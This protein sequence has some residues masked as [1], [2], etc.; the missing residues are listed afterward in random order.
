MRI[1]V[2]GASGFIG[3]H[4]L[5]ALAEHDVEVTALG[6]NVSGDLIGRPGVRAVALD[7]AEVDERTFDR[8]GRPDA[9]IHLAWGGLPNY[10]SPH[11]FETE[12][13]QQYK[14]LSTLVKSGLGCVIAAGT[15]PR[16]ASTH[17]ARPRKGTGGRPPQVFSEQTTAAARHRPASARSWALRS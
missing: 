7:M 16:M 5:A 1:A 11:H 6:R 9:L 12:L 14:F 3:R 8:I 17:A 13:P 10:R 4:V 15:S 2:T